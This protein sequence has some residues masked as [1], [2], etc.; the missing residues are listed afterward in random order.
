MAIL[1]LVTLSLGSQI[2]VPRTFGGFLQVDEIL[3]GSPAPTRLFA[4]IYL[5]RYQPPDLQAV[6]RYR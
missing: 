5:L 4:Q 3:E 1:P 6:E 2:S